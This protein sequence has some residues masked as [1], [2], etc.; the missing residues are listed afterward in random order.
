MKKSL[1]GITLLA[2]SITASAADITTEQRS[3]VAGLKDSLTQS[4]PFFE[5][6]VNS[7][8]KAYAEW[9]SLGTFAKKSYAK[10]YCDTYGPD[11]V[12]AS[13]AFYSVYAKNREAL[14]QLP[15]ASAKAMNHNLLCAEN[16]LSFSLMYCKEVGE[17]AKLAKMA[18]DC[19]NMAIVQTDE[20]LTASAPKPGE[21]AEPTK[22]S[23]PT[24]PSE[25]SEPSLPTQN[26]FDTAGGRT[27]ENREK[28]ATLRKLLYTQRED[29]KELARLTSLK[30]DSWNSERW[31][32]SR[33]R[34]AQRNCEEMSKAQSIVK[35]IGALPVAVLDAL[36]ASNEVN[37]LKANLHSVYS[38]F[39]AAQSQCSNVPASF[40]AISTSFTAF[41]ASELLLEKILIGETKR[42]EDFQRM[43]TG[44][45]KLYFLKDYRTETGNYEVLISLLSGQRCEI[46]LV[47]S[48]RTI[49]AGS[50]YLVSH[51][52]HNPSTNASMEFQYGLLFSVGLG[53]EGMGIFCSKGINLNELQGILNRVGIEIRDL[54]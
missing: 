45:T 40:Q 36:D 17:S 41:K 43:V 54:D 51:Q 30:N 37:S 18:I 29:L 49:P 8:S 6:I 1:V 10:K 22:P 12:K 3:L 19:L 26:D 9:S 24:R 23:E 13:T 42:E 31:N 28:L 4:R 39:I 35:Q 5:A 14:K 48:G 33:K 32:D 21:P 46:H 7:S 38:N 15:G 16:N 34:N 47:V 52:N 11:T 20:I 44:K 2:M 53:D 25:P 50:E 27:L